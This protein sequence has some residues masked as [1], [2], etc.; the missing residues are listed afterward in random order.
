VIDQC[1]GVG[2]NGERALAIDSAVS[3]TFR[4]KTSKPL[5][6]HFQNETKKGCIWYFFVES[7]A[8]TSERK[9]SPDYVLETRLMVE[10]VVVR[11]RVVQL[12]SESIFKF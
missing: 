3:L 8:A 11:V 6:E 1:V 9:N 10:T 4:N 2:S 12:C 5:S 7:G